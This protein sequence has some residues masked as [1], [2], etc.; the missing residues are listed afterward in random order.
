MPAPNPPTDIIERSIIA[1]VAVL[2]ANADIKAITDRNSDNVT[3]WNADMLATLP[4]IAYRY[5]VATPGGMATGDTR[6][7]LFL[8]T[9]VGATESVT[10]AL[11]EAIEKIRWAPALAALNPPLDGCMYNPVRRQIPWDEDVDAYRS[12]LE[13]TL[14]VTK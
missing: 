6:E 11:L 13:Y 14:V 5:T 1:V 9:A 10:N 3:A 4:V 8:F 12:D 7:V 2:E